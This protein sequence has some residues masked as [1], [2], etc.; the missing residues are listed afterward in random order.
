[1]AL[2]SRVAHR[3]HPRVYTAV[4][5]PTHSRARAPGHTLQASILRFGTGLA[6]RWFELRTTPSD[7]ARSSEG[8]FLLAQRLRRRTAFI[9]GRPCMGE[10][11][12][13]LHVAGSR[14]TGQ[15]P[16]RNL[17]CSR[18]AVRRLPP[19]DGEGTSGRIPRCSLP[20]PRTGISFFGDELVSTERIVQQA[21]CRVILGTPANTL[22]K[23]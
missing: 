9:R 10:H 22:R 19:A 7:G 11:G 2:F 5:D 21:A 23:Q 16:S 4:Q 17:A 20:C 15:S 13:P 12:R 18:S 14:T 3:T 6:R 1:M 8:A